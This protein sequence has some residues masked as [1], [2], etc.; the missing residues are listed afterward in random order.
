[1]KQ[2]TLLFLAAAALTLSAAPKAGTARFNPEAVSARYVKLGKEPVHT[3][4][5]KGK[6]QCEIVIPAKSVA[7]VKF[8]GYEL[9]NFLEKIIGSKVP[10]VT[11]PTGKRTA[12]LLGA[13][14]AKAIGADLSKI[15]RDGF[16]IRSSGKNIVIAG[17]DDPKAQPAKR[18][19]AAERGT[20]NGVYEFL[21]RFGGVRF[22][23][24]G[25]M[26]TVVPRKADWRIGSID[27]ADRPD[28]Q[29]RRTYCVNVKALGVSP[30]LN[31]PGN[32]NESD[33]KRLSAMRIRESTLAIPNC[34]GLRGLQITKRFAK[35]NPEYFALRADGTRFDGSRVIRKDDADGHL[36][37]TNDELKEV[38]YQDALAYFTGKPA[39]TRGITKWSTNYFSGPFFNIMPN[40]SLYPCRC[41]RCV[42]ARLEHDPKAD[43]KARRQATSD[44]IW[45]FKSDIAR[46]LL[47]EGIP[48]YC[49]M[50]AYG[51]ARP[52]P[53]M[54]LC[55]NIIVQLALTGPWKE[56]NPAVQKRDIE[57]LAAWKKKLN[58]KTYLWNYTTKI[59][60]GLPYVPCFTPRSVGSFFKKTAPYSFGAFLEAELDF[61]I[62][63]SMNF[64]V[65]GKVLW[66]KDT[67][68]D[69]LMNEHFQL[70]YGSAAKE[71]EEFY[72]TLERHWAKDIMANIKEIP[73]G[74]QAVLPSQFDIWNK[75]YGPA[76]IKRI[77]KLFD[78]AEKLTAQDRMANKRVKFMR[79]E[80]W[81]PVLKG[82]KQFHKQNNDRS[83]WNIYADSPATPIV[84]DGKL[85]EGA[86]KNAD[87]VW[88]IPARGDVG[89]VHTRVKM[90]ADKDYFYFG[91]ENDEPLT[92][93]MLCADR[94]R[95]EINTW[96]DNLV[97][98]FISD[99]HTSSIMYQF[100][101][102]SRGNVVDIRKSPGHLSNKWNC[103]LVYKPGVIP[104]KM[105]VAEVKIPRK[106]M[107]EIKGKQFVIN[108]T[109][110][111]VLTDATAYK[112]PYYAWSIFKKQ[113]AEYCG[114]AFIGK[115]PASK[116]IIKNG[117][118]DVKVRGKR[119]A[120]AWYNGKVIYVDDKVYRSCG[121]S[122]RIE[123]VKGAENLRQ[124][125]SAKAFKPKAR[126]RFSY[127][128][129]LEKVKG[130]GGKAGAG[131]STQIRFGGGGQSW[132]RPSKQAFQGTTD[133][134]R[135]EYEF[136]AP[137]DPGSKG[138][139]YIEFRLSLNATGK[140]WIDN[141]EIIEI[142]DKK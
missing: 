78:R 84:I 13:A 28:S 115:R 15:D 58:A 66:N 43:A 3:L 127:F 71:M 17:T 6:A 96:R 133:W 16:L 55:S 85:S 46:K 105:W 8:A 99:K 29:F 56:Y 106:A 75:I 116:N 7:V 30:K 11:A 61:W 67:D 64:Y 70:M 65:F 103:A 1:M 87:T 31:T 124:Y 51:A 83:A 19:Q 24:P 10:V 27:L 60:N 118:F 18:L 97:E 110:G 21:E 129:K 42:K 126:Y 93:K 95:D 109:R 104:G 132:F 47:K 136:T 81:G 49:T 39:S 108:F 59:G 22:Y 139:P 122:L 117:N 14:G 130:K 74:P 142:S 53:S 26:G 12:F 125:I 82:M 120:G 23:F 123:A 107:P 73:V 119:F 76:E 135:L 44:H 25:E 80:L 114:T 48:G 86:W 72:N 45:K 90:L 20:L 9:K 140:A 34:H 88:L 121:K 38:V 62:F 102:N 91:F 36:C 92:S 137:A 5:S 112:M 101:L 69:A 68:V 100:M 141:V 2:I 98:I 4:A 138:K 37:F 54:E 113:T 89:E 40:D 50:M 77:E 41:P 33:L 63:N 35:S 111:R 52:I 128:V 131:F 79:K 134:R 57:L 94:K 32:M